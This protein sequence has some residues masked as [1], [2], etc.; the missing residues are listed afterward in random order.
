MVG[1]NFRVPKYHPI[2]QMGRG[3]NFTR[4]RV[5]L[6]KFALEFLPLFT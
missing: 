2:C 6:G 5:G 4:G 1:R 3:E